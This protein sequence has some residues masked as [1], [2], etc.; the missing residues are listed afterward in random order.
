MTSSILFI[1]F[2]LC[3]ILIISDLSMSTMVYDLNAHTCGPHHI[4]CT[5]L[6][7]I[8]AEFKKS[9][10]SSLSIYF[11]SHNSVSVL[12]LRWLLTSALSAT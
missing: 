1:L 2:I 3:S 4:N 11:L 9:Q 10:V 6:Y 12:P 7:S 8:Y 5:P